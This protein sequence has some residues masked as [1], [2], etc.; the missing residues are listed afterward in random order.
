MIFTMREKLKPNYEGKSIVRNKI[1]DPLGFIP[2]KQKIENYI[3]AGI[4]LQKS[5]IEQYDA[6]SNVKPEDILKNPYR[7]RGMEFDDIVRSKKLLESRIEGKIKAQKEALERE[8][9]RI[10][11]FNK[12]H[13]D[14][15]K[16]EE[17]IGKKRGSERSERVPRSDTE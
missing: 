12:N 3:Q 4:R 7:D 9:R 15:P 6:D 2:H 13:P 8:E 11:E 5:R 17:N 10:R 16:F 1:V 14:L